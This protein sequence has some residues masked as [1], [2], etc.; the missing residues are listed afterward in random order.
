MRQGCPSERKEPESSGMGAAGHGGRELF[1]TPKSC[2]PLPTA[3]RKYQMGSPS[4]KQLVGV[5]QHPLWAVRKSP[6]CHSPQDASPPCP[7]CPGVHAPPLAVR[8]TSSHP[9]S[10]PCHTAPGT[11][12]HCGPLLCLMHRPP[13][14][15]CA[16]ELALALAQTDGGAR[17]LAV[18]ST[19]GR[20]LARP[21]DNRHTHCI[22][23]PGQNPA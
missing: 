15:A 20:L 6:A 21:D 10:V 17:R 18:T 3:V 9:L 13:C 2:Y 8:K 19:Q 22:P 11:A 16:G 23:V 7:A 12:G 4:N 1:S 14:A 5:T